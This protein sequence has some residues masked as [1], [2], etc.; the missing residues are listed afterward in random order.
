MNDS[1][2]PGAQ[3]SGVDGA[4]AKNSMS[5]GPVSRRRRARPNRF[6]QLIKWTFAVGFCLVLVAGGALIGRYGKNPT[7]NKIFKDTNLGDWF[8]GNPLAS[9]TPAKYLP[10][11]PHT[12]NLLILGCDRDYVGKRINGEAVPVP[13]MN[14]NGR[15]DAILVAHYDF[16]NQA[17]SVMTIPRDTAVHI[18]GHSTHK[19]NAAHQFG[20]PAL[21]QETIKAAFGIDTDAY[22]TL[23]FE[24]FQKIVDTVGG[25]DIDVKKQLDYDDKWARLHIHL[26]PG[27]QHLDG[28]QAMGYVR[29]RHSDSDLMRA[30]RQHE[31]LEALR[32]QIRTP[33]MLIKGA[34]VLDTI[35][36]NLHS[37]LSTQQLIALAN[38]TK[39]LDKKSIALVTM[40]SI[41]GPSYITVNRKLTRKMVAQIFFAG[42]EDAV[43]INAPDKETLSAS[44]HRSH[45]K[46]HSRPHDYTPVDLNSDAPLV[47]E[48]TPTPD[49]TAP[50]KNDSTPDKSDN[51]S[52]TPK[53]DGG[54]APEKKNNDADDKS[55]DSPP[56]KDSP[57]AVAQLAFLPLT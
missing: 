34:D 50:R 14:T 54:S 37:S 49:T 1:E 19:I 44:A 42:N 8:R 15:S 28:Y 55:K 16:D 52:S 30:E 2:Q 32:N 10:D 18:P 6:W 7:V 48:P 45:R 13:L 3:S 27:M 47:E 33:A 26:K 39:G 21:T 46:G 22:V 40:P 9:Y 35:T 57:S 56:A 20:G 11:H 41:E 31:F 25:V 38:W 5:N 51:P 23:H 17:V 4:G 29:I 43:T 24:A 12:L 53:S 36:D